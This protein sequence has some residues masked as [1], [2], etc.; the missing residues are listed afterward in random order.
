[1]SGLLNIGL[2]GIGGYGES[3]LETLLPK[4][5]A[6]GVRI[7]GV[8]DP[9][10]T[11]CGHL[12]ELKARGIPI[13]PT[14]ASLFSETPVIYFMMIATPIHLHSPQ[15]IFSLQ[16]GASVLCEKPLGGTLPDAMRMQHAERASSGFVAIGF[17]WSF[18]AAIQALKHDIMSGALG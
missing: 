4:A 9:Q 14:L 3:Y 1:M 11:R 18:S 17:Q 12:E 2:A 5:R 16:H 7:A 15:T 6:A 13:H 10:P 8:V